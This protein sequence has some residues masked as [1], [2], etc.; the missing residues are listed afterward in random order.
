MVITIIALNWNT[1]FSN[2]AKIVPKNS[3][4][5]KGLKNFLGFKTCKFIYFG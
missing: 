2:E 5:R 4:K 3:L 1:R